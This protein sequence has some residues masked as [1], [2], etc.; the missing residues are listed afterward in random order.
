[1]GKT[2]AAMGTLCL[3]GVGTQT[4]LNDS[5]TTS[6]LETPAGRAK[7]SSS[8]SVPSSK[9][10]LAGKDGVATGPLDGTLAPYILSAMR[11]QGS[12]KEEVELD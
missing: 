3:A 9:T 10:W 8:I 5:S 4:S 6:L 7:G 1:M 12:I 2:V 11:R